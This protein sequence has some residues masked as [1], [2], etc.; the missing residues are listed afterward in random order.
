MPNTEELENPNYEYATLIIADDG[1]TEIGRYFR[2]NREWTNFSSLNP[3]L[4]DALI[5]TEDERFYNHTGIDGRAVL[6]AVANLGRKGGG[7][8]ITQQLGLSLIHI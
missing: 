8:T 4:T 6:R 2:K 7:S 1:R 5:A 3:H